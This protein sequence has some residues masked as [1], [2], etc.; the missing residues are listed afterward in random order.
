MLE[1]IPDNVL[2]GEGSV[3]RGGRPFNRFFSEREVALRVGR[4]CLLDNVHFALGKNAELH[5]GNQCYF[6]SA[7]LLCEQRIIVGN[8]VVVGWNAAVMDT[9]FHPLDPA[10]RIADA[11]ACS[12]IAEGRKR[13][14]IEG[15]AVCIEDDV[16]IGPNATILKGV[17]V[18]TGS[19]IE[20]GTVVTTDVPPRSVVF[21]NPGRIKRTA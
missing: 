12:P 2:L 14:I 11:I 19:F 10:Q 9:D 20:P 8:R 3:I 17:T 5:I 21:G 6:T 7:V 1:N 15:A 16:W 18:G 13:P 4:E